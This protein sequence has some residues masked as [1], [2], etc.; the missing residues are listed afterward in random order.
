MRNRKSEAKKKR[1]I[2]EKAKPLNII[3]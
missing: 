3:D 1:K 2:S